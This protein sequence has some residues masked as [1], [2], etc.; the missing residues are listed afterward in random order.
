[1][2]KLFAG[3]LLGCL[4]LTFCGLVIGEDVMFIGSTKARRYHYPSC[5]LVVKIKPRS[6]VK[7][8]SLKEAIASGLH[9]CPV[10]KPPST[11]E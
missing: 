8:Y 2:K 3:V 7:F 6:L 4:V 1:M 9:P 10:C 11:I 5:E